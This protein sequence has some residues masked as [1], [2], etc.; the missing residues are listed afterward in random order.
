M[1]LH[2]ALIT[3]FTYFDVSYKKSSHIINNANIL[4]DI[5]YRLIANIFIE[6]SVKHLKVMSSVVR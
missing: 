5:L 3:R 4:P 1:E 2:F 6:F